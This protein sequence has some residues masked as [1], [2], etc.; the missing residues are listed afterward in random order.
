MANSLNDRISTVA[1]YADAL[2]ASYSDLR[3]RLK[4]ADA[5]VTTLKQQVD[6]LRSQINSLEQDNRFL[7]ISYRLA[8]DPDTIIESRR[9]ISGLIRNI[10]KAIVDLK[11]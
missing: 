10:D 7:R 2:I 9:L 8:A 3:Q 4:D 5:E 1:R 6:V 11:E